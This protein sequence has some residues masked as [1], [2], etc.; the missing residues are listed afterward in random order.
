MDERAPRAGLVCYAAPFR[1]CWVRG[2]SA[3]Q[4]CSISTR[5]YQRPPIIRE[6]TGGAFGVRY[7]RQ[8]RLSAPF[9]RMT[10]PERV[11]VYPCCLQSATWL[12]VEGVFPMAA[13][14]CAAPGLVF[15]S[16]PPAHR[17]RGLF[18][19]LS[20]HRLPL[21]GFY[22]WLYPRIAVPPYLTRQG[23]LLSVSDF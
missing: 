7:T 19:Y 22:R 1:P 12:N 8:P 9:V 16:S 4:G 18:G 17:T 10:N 5:R 15:R 13:Q 2:L 23:S 21:P 11:K 6:W 20:V 3:H 14:S